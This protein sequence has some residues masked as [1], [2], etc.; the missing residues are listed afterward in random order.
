MVIKPCSPTTFCRETVTPVSVPPVASTNG[1][2]NV[3]VPAGTNVSVGLDAS[4][5][6]CTNTPCTYVWTLSC[7]GASD[8]TF[9]GAQPTIKAGPGA[10]IST[11]NA[12]SP[13]TCTAS[14][15]VTDSANLTS[16]ANTTVTVT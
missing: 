9:T 3:T 6:T 2:L 8:Q 10:D 14:L 13:I 1:P 4:S 12:T 11:T 15:L 16:T 5:S 7:P